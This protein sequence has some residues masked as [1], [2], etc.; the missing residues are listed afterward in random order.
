M[1]AAEIMK[2]I[3][4]MTPKIADSCDTLKF[5]SAEKNVKKAAVTCIATVE[6]IKA[7]AEWGADMIIT[8]EPTFFEH[9]DNA[10]INDEI[11]QKKTWMLRETGITIYRFHDGMHAADF[12]MI[13]EGELHYMGLDGVFEKGEDFACNRFTLNEPMTAAELAALMNERLNINHIRIC[14]EKTKKS[15]NLSLCFG[16]PGDGIFKEL[17]RKESEIVIAGEVCEWQ[18]GEY[19]RDAAALGFN[20]TLM[21]LGHMGSE[22][23]GMQLLQKRLSEEYLQIEF[24]YFDCGEVY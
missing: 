21:I 3:Y 16:A 8:H 13:A 7:A 17:K 1:T 23:N 6:V 14:G 4:G 2:E 18:W 9:M 22:R 15:K 24:K 12:D 10:D 5:G 20:K 11:T 19:A